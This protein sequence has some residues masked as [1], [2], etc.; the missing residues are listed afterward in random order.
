MK[1]LLALALSTACNLPL[2]YEV[3]YGNIEPIVIEKCG[4]DVIFCQEFALDANCQD[5][6]WSD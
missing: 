5:C 4:H 6:I 3:Q 1:F 2:T